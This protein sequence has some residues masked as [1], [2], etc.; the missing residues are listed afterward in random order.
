MYDDVTNRVSP[1]NKLLEKGVGLTLQLAVIRSLTFEGA[2]MSIYCRRVIEIFSLAMSCVPSLYAQSVTL[3]NSPVS[4]PGPTLLW[5]QTVQNTGSWYNDYMPVDLKVDSSNNIYVLTIQGGIASGP[6][7]ADIVLIK[8]DQRGTLLWQTEYDGGYS[9]SGVASYDIPTEM[10]L[11]SKGN[12]LVTGTVRSFLYESNTPTYDDYILI[13]Y[14]SSGDQLWAAQYRGTGTSTDEPMGLAIDS[15]DNIYVTGTSWNLNTQ[16]DYATLKYSPDGELLWS[17]AI[18]S[19]ANIDVASAIQ[20]NFDGVFVTG[21]SYFAIPPFQTVF[22]VDYLT[23][24]LDS[25]SGAVLWSRRH[26]PSQGFTDIATEMVLD[27]NGNII[28]SGNAYGIGGA[29]NLAYATVKYDSDGNEIW[30]ARYDGPASSSGTDD[31]IPFDIAADSDDNVIV[32]GSSWNTTFPEIATIQYDGESGGQNWIVRTKGKGANNT[33][34][35]IRNGLLV[36]PDDSVYVAGWAQVPG[37]T[38]GTTNFLIEK[39]SA[40]GGTLWSIDYNSAGDY[41]DEATQIALD[42]RGR[43]VV[44][45]QGFLT[46]PPGYKGFIV[47]KYRDN[48]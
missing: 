18:D 11:D 14:S 29:Y 8:Y 35:T 22:N 38:S 3:A 45:G 27:K 31:D 13:K 19:S 40:Q 26:D 42:S 12:I 15:L 46:P 39:Y 16:F 23:V 48:L 1:R 30:T 47:Q 21:Y 10:A 4:L 24:K 41:H 36:G 17:S 32:T 37:T 25:E 7:N 5:Q 34:A 9:G 33:S 28:V 43:I 20:V 2:L 6:Q 44:A